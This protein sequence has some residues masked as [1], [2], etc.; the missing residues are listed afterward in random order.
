NNYEKKNGKVFL[1]P[2]NEKYKPI[3]VTEKNNF[4]LVGKV[5]GVLRWFN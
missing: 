2:Q 3:I 4:S 5:V 1:I